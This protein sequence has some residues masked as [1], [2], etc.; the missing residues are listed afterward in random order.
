MAIITDISWYRGEDVVLTDSIK[1]AGGAAVNITGWS[2][3][4]TLKKAYGD[5]AAVLTKSTAGGGITIT[6]GP[7]GVLQ[8]TIASADTASLEVRTYVYDIQ[9]IDAGSRAVLSI[10]NATIKPEVAL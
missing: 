5:A 10:G 8:V 2:L 1:D 3:Q 6:N 7:G 4:F 9:R